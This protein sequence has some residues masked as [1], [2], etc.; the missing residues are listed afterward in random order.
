MHQGL[1]V[2]ELLAWVKVI[3]KLAWSLHSTNAQFLGLDSKMPN[4][5]ELR[6][7]G[8]HQK[9]YQPLLSTQY[10]SRSVPWLGGMS[11]M[12]GGS[13]GN[14]AAWMTFS[15]GIKSKLWHSNFHHRQT[16][17]TAFPSEC[18]LALCTCWSFCACQYFQDSLAGVTACQ[19][20]PSFKSK[21]SS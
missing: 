10:Q 18:C 17:H 19:I 16:P 11:G 5:I 7:G 13:R 15:D 20:F 9:N 14:L 8:L 4:A 12:Q 2:P 21:S 3:L 1:N 6:R